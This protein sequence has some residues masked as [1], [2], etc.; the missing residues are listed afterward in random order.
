MT[1]QPGVY[2]LKGN[3]GINVV[4]NEMRFNGFRPGGTRL[5]APIGTRKGKPQRKSLAKVLRHNSGKIPGQEPEQNAVQ[6]NN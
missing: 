5:L 6:N 2:G 3:G 4:V 1:F